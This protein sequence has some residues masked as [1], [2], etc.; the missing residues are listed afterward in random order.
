MTK[1]KVL[2]WIAGMAA[3]I[4]IVT[5]C[6][7]DNRKR[8]KELDEYWRNQRETLIKAQ[9][10][11]KALTEHFQQQT[12]E[13]HK[14]MEELCAAE[15]ICPDVVAELKAEGKWLETEEDGYRYFTE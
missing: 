14:G 1:G 7:I 5:W 10:Q 4:G 13:L 6:E 15:V 11:A 8:E 12:I 3:S 9:E 2:A